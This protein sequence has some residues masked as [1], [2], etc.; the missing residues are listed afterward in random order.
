MDQQ[1]AAVA[2]VTVPKAKIIS[3]VLRI[4]QSLEMH[5]EDITDCTVED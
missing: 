4:Q 3:A 1:P 2:F 5:R